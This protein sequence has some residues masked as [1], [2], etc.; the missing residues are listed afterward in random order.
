LICVSR[1]GE[2]KRKP[3]RATSIVPPRLPTVVR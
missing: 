1:I 2:R 3:A